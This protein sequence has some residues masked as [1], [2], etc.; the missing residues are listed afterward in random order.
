MSFVTPEQ[1][2]SKSLTP[3]PGDKGKQYQTLAEQD[4]QEYEA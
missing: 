4:V 2:H 1:E 3:M